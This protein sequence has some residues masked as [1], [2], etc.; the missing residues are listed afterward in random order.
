[1]TTLEKMAY[2]RVLWAKFLIDGGDP[3]IATTGWFE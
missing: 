1:M 2:E 3:T